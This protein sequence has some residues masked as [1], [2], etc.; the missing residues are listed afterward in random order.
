MSIAVMGLLLLSKVNEAQEETLIMRHLVFF[1]RFHRCLWQM[2]LHDYLN[3]NEKINVVRQTLLE[4]DLYV[5]MIHSTRPKCQT[6]HYLGGVC[7]VYWEELGLLLEL[8]F[9]KDMP[10]R[11]AEDSQSSS[12]SSSS[13][14]PRPRTSSRELRGSNTTSSGSRAGNVCKVHT[15][16]LQLLCA[17]WC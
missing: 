12:S 16:I 11:R 10:N 17:V 13:F 9:M 8:R 6:L 1:T 5:N 7:L 2:I 14:S 15:F 3:R 4:K